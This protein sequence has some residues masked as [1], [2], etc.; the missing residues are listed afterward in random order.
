VINKDTGKLF[1]V[2]LALIET[3]GVSQFTCKVFI[4][5]GITTCQNLKISFLKPFKN[6]DIYNYSLVDYIHSQ[7]KVKIICPEHG[8]FEQSPNNHLS[9]QGCSSC[10]GLK[11]LTSETFISN[12]IQK[13]G[14]IYMIIH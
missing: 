10:V 5:E 1:R 9:G 13:H 2:L 4:N 12:A 8:T 3:E 14:H 11:K 6:T 7:C